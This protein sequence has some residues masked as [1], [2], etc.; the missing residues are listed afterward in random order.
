MNLKKLFIN[1]LIN[2]GLLLTGAFVF[3]MAFPNFFTDWGWGFLAFFSLIPVF[4][5]VH[6]N[7]LIENLFWGFLYGLITYKVHNFWLAEFNPTAH[8]VVP[9]IYAVY[10]MLV[11]PLMGWAEKKKP[12]QAWI[13]YTVFW[14][15]YEVLRTKGF[16]GYSYGIIGYSQYNFLSFIG[17]SDITG[18]LGVS[19]M[20]VLP[21]ALIA[22]RINYPVDSE[23]K[24]LTW[25]KPLGLYAAV[26]LLVNIYGWLAMVD[27]SDSKIWRPALIQ[28]NESAWLSG[29]EV[30]KN[31]YEVLVRVSDEAL[32]EDPDVV[33]W[34]ETSFVPAIEWHE[35]Y[36]LEPAKLVLIQR[37]R[38]FLEE[39]DTPF[40]I[41]NNDSKMIQ[42]DKK[43]WNA[44]LLLEEGEIVDR[45]HKIQ[46]V[47]FG[48]HFPYKKLFPRFYQYLLDE[49]ITIYQAGDE[50][51]IM[52]TGG[53]SFGSLVCYEDTFPY[54][55]RNFVKRGSEVLVN[56]T[57]D[58]WSSANASCMQHG[59][60]A[61]FRSV[62]NRRSMV[63]ST[64]SGFTTAIDPNGRFLEY[65]EPFT[66]GYLIPEV[67]IY[68][69]RTTLF[70]R[71]GSW[72]DWFSLAAALLIIV[73][74][75]RD[76]YLMKKE[77]ENDE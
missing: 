62:E 8:K 42:G 66:E 17:I 45:Y 16:L 21:S 7:S 35:K 39:R 11:F 74:I 19:A 47:P 18:V 65:L 75:K 72:F 58:A 10:F 50:W 26:F 12:R 57:N 29:M 22:W 51:T 3:S 43:N 53:I 44:V 28:H 9:I 13:I 73:W 6:R 34:P 69:E 52:E 15:A 46:L 4:L 68:T 59:I 5:M 64:C 23:K 55:A 77:E 54:L 67:P 63:R 38:T 32:K 70:T 31:S 25:V 2:M 36:R 27:T 40:I 1:S 48:E 20:V 56:L 71:L 61:V 33:I 41:G 30:Y 37:L 14:L 60:M 49:G 24:W 76:D